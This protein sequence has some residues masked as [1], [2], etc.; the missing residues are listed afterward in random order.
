L[1]GTFDGESF[2]SESPDSPVLWVDEGKDFYATNVWN[3]APLGEERRILIG[4]LSDWQ[5][6]NVE[7]TKIWRG[8]QSLPR[9]LALRRYADGLRLVQ[10][11]ISEVQSLRHE[12]L[13]LENATIE[14]ANRRIQE[15][16]VSGE[17]Y[18]LEAELEPGQTGEIGLRLRKGKDTET[19]AGIDA[20]HGEVF[21]DR[22]R[23]G[24]ISFSKDFPGRH[25]AK[26]E[27]GTSVKLQ[28]FVD[29]SSVEM[30]S[31][32][33]ERVLSDRIYP[34]AGSDGIELYAKGTGGRA[35]S[36][37]LWQLDSVWK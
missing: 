10:S 16:G 37:I 32:G 31:N 13:R 36:L 20:V 27:I 7:P 33:G 1:I 22:T 4:W 29:R 23:S 11:P 21:I 34:P 18:E 14:Q 9:L 26:I 8:A 30:F 6:A 25:S 35:L 28:V 24:E 19:L 2:T 3:N 5:Y 12:K 17:V 15:S